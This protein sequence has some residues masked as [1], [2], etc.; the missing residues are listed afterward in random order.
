MLQ[1]TNQGKRVDLEDLIKSPRAAGSKNQ[2]ESPLKKRTG[3][4]IMGAHMA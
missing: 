2:A 4:G 1:I 3:H